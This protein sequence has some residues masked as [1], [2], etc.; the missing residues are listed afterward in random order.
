M[1][2]GP[3]AIQALDNKSLIFGVARHNGFIAGPGDGG[4]HYIAIGIDDRVFARSR[5]TIDIVGQITAVPVAPYAIAIP[6]LVLQF[7]DLDIGIEQ[8]IAELEIV[9]RL[10]LQAERS[11][12]TRFLQALGLGLRA[13]RGIVFCG[14]AGDHRAIV[15]AGIIT[16]ALDRLVAI[17]LNLRG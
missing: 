16:P 12:D 13:P 9:A 14:V 17:L 10:V 4:R 2:G 8:V 3:F 5:G 1:F 7:V 15:G 11:P 6:G